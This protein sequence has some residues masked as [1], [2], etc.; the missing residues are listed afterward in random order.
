M[1]Q[2][3]FTPK[4]SH[5]IEMC[6]IT[7][8]GSVK[9][10]P[11]ISFNMRVPAVTVFNYS[12]QTL[13]HP[14]TRIR[15]VDHLFCF[16]TEV[17]HEEGK[18]IIILDEGR[19]QGF[20]MNEVFIVI[21]SWYRSHNITNDEH[22]EMCSYFDSFFN[23]DLPVSALDQ[24]TSFS[25]GFTLNA[26]NW[27]MCYVN[28]VDLRGMIPPEWFLEKKRED[29]EA[30]NAIVRENTNPVFRAESPRTVM[31]DLSNVFDDITVSSLDFSSDDE[32]GEDLAVSMA[33]GILD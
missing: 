1:E 6:K 27:L 14:F 12:R 28:R 31:A 33:V 5:K 16:K 19:I 4:C 22:A 2:L 3:I 23:N 26:Y 7:S 25:R 10:V 24:I 32:D 20:K 13:V 30:F 17:E 8:L 15:V 11:H 29:M 9:Y 18:V 21:D